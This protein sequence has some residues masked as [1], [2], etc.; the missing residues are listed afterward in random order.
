MRPV[1]PGDQDARLTRLISVSDDPKIYLPPVS[2]DLFGYRLRIS[3]VLRL[4][5]S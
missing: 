1:C 4:E 5:P 2:E 3:M